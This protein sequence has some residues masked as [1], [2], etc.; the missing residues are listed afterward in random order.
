MINFNMKF[1]KHGKSSAS[2][3]N[4]MLSV[5]AED[6]ISPLIGVESTNYYHPIRRRI[7]TFLGSYYQVGI[8]A[9]NTLEST[10]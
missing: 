2:W 3:Y 5:M 8:T 4:E 6:V 9:W 1:V 10:S 7:P